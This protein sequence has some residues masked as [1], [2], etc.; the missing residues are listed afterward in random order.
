MVMRVVMAVIM[1]VGVVVIM[2]MVRILRRL[3]RLCCHATDLPVKQPR[4]KQRNQTPACRLKPRLGDAQ[5]HAGGVEDDGLYA[6]DNDR[7]N[8]LHESSHERQQN[9]AADGARVGEGIR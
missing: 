7:R 8:R 9:A 2:V 5:L 1:I 4:T 3:L 6:H